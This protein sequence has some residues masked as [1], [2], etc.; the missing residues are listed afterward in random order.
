MLMNVSL[1][2]GSLIICFAS[3]ALGLAA[4]ES[5]ATPVNNLEAQAA[6]NH[7]DPLPNGGAQQ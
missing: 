2:A 4:P 3:G 7:Q 6:A 5:A 1:L